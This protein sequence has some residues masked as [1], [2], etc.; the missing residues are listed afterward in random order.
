MVPLRADVSGFRLRRDEGGAVD[1]KAANL[2]REAVLSAIAEYDKIGRGR[3]S[4]WTGFHAESCRFEA[5]GR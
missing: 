3:N 4:D 2:M 5:F 1:R